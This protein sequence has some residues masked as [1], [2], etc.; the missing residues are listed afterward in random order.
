MHPAATSEGDSHTDTSTQSSRGRREASSPVRCSSSSRSASRVHPARSRRTRGQPRRPGLDGV[1]VDEAYA[2]RA[3]PGRRAGMRKGTDFAGRPFPGLPCVR[4]RV[5]YAD[6][7]QATARSVASRCGGWADSPATGPRNVAPGQ[8]S[9]WVC[10]RRR[11]MLDRR[12]HPPERRAR[13]DGERCHVDVG[14]CHGGQGML[15]YTLHEPCL[16][17]RPKYMLGSSTACS[18]TSGVLTRR[19]LAGRSGLAWAE[20]YPQ[21]SINGTNR[22]PS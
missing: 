12:P 18:T 22:P 1:M 13:P 8:R 9:A 20:P 17:Q 3:K 14:T 5:G 16:R 4:S 19:G 15:P 11:P 2:A 6:S 10:G 7:S 21:A